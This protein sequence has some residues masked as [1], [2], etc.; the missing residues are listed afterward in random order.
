M[1]HCH[2]GDVENNAYMIWDSH[3][4]HIVPVCRYSAGLFPFRASGLTGKA[5]KD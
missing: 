2:N 1:K 4:N 3:I 5:E